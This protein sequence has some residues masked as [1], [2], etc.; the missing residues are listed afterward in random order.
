MGCNWRVLRSLQQHLDE[1]A[2]GVCVVDS[3]PSVPTH[4]QSPRVGKFRKF[5]V[6]VTGNNVI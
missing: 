1:L 3:V 2:P 4:V 5:A 6:Q